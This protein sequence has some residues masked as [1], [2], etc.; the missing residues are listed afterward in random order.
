MDFIVLVDNC[1][2]FA[3]SLIETEDST[4]WL[5]LC[6][7]PCTAVTHADLIPPHLT[8]S[9]TIDTLPAMPEL[10]ISEPDFLCEYCLV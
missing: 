4:L 2:R 6:G 8:E 7:R 3:E 1:A 5:T 9:L 10:V